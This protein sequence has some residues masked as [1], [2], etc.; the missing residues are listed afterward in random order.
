MSEYLGYGLLLGIALI[1]GFFV[2]PY[3][4]RKWLGISA[5]VLGGVAAFIVVP[6]IDGFDL[7]ALPIMLLSFGAGL[8]FDRHRYSNDD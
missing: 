6:K 5:F 4:Y 3:R 2:R 8:F 7:D 1:L